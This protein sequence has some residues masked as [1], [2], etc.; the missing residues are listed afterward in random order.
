[1][2][3][4][5]AA[6][7]L[8]EGAVLLGFVAGGALAGLV[9]GRA[10]H[11]DRC[12]ACGARLPARA[13]RCVS[14]GVTL[15]GAVSSDEERLATEDAAQSPEPEYDYF[16]DPAISE[17]AKAEA[18]ILG[19]IFTEWIFRRDLVSQ[20]FRDASPARFESARR[21]ELSTAELFELSGDE[22]AFVNETAAAFSEAYFEK[23]GAWRTDDYVL[24]TT[25]NRIRDTRACYGRVQALLDRR[26]EEWLAAR[27]SA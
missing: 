1:M 13:E 19:A 11:D 18:R 6:T 15:S 2:A 9:V 25:A 7:G 24:L 26:F 23:S 5:F 17:G 8:I 21:G 16:A 3:I 14:C 27:E 22:A 10:F 12:S 20:S 4:V